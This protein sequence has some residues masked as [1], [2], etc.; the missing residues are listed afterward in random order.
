MLPTAD[1]LAPGI[2]KALML[3]EINAA[4]DGQVFGDRYYCTNGQT[5]GEPCAAAYPGT[6]AVGIGYGLMGHDNRDVPKPVAGWHDVTA[7]LTTGLDRL[8]ADLRQPY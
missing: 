7:N 2:P 4:S 6:R 8:A 5:A 3:A 1:R